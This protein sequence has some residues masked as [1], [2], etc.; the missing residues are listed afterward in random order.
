MTANI[1]NREEWVAQ[2]TGELKAFFE[3]EPPGDVVE[4]AAIKLAVAEWKLVAVRR[5]VMELG[6]TPQA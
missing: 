1:D 3:K 4:V 2:R 6:E 5:Q